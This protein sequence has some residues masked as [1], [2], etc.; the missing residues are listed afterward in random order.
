[1][2]F[3]SCFHVLELR[4]LGKLAQLLELVEVGY[5]VVGHVEHPQLGQLLNIGQ[6][7]DFV[8]G[9]PQLLEL[10][11]REGAHTPAIVGALLVVLEQ[12]SIHKYQH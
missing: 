2:D 9:Q 7:L 8:V 11:V 4:K 5:R 12:V 3:P 10:E 1:M 6:L